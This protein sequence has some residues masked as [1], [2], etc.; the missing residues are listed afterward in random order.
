MKKV[1]CISSGQLVTKKKNHEIHRQNRYLNYGLLSLASIIKKNGVD[2]YQIQGN[3]E[4]PETIY[5]IAVNEGIEQTTL[6]LLLSI[7]SFY[8]VSWANEFL[9]ILKS[10]NPNIKVIVGGRWVIDDEVERMKK[11]MPLVDIVVDGLGEGK[12]LDLLNIE[13]KGGDIVLH[14]VLDYTLLHDRALYQPSIEIARGCG[15]GCGFCQEKDEPLSKFKSGNDICHEARGTILQDDLIPMN[16]YLESSIFIPNKRW[17]DSLLFNRDASNQNFRWRTEARVDS[18]KPKFM[19]ELKA[20]GL[21][22]I[23]LGLESADK[24]Q[25]LRM[26]KTKNPALYLQRAS[27]LIHSAYDAGVKVKVNILLF[28]G[29]SEKSIGNTMKWLDQH[30]HLITG[31]SI[32]PVILFGWPHKTTNYLDELNNYG[33]SNSHEAVLGARHINLSKKID[34]EKSMQW[35]KEI[36]QRYTTAADYFFLKSFSYFSREYT[37][38]KFLA[39][40]IKIEDDLNFRVTSNCKNLSN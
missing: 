34:Y 22:V 12:I 13:C 32:G 24:D 6:P 36:G 17:I 1:F 16:A 19:K 5:N 3:F 33:A 2:A 31:V 38:D 10:N 15:M 26:Q 7:P 18:V 20:C 11:L 23:D 4:S 28:A 21:E 29:E 39:D 35:S 37:Y 14:S 9:A 40:T 8:A 25:L 30:K 27:E